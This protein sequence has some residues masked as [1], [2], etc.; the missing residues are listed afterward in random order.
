M[1][2][3]PNRCS[4]NAPCDL[5]APEDSNHMRYTTPGA[6]IPAPMDS[7]PTDWTKERLEECGGWWQQRLS[8]G[9]WKLRYELVPP[10]KLDEHAKASVDWSADLAYGVVKVLDPAK[11]E[12]EPF[13]PTDTE[14]NVVHELLHLHTIG[15]Q[16]PFERAEDYI[17]KPLYAELK[18]QSDEAEEQL[19]NHIARALVALK[20]E[21]KGESDR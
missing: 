15:L 14:V 2:P 8:L 4:P 12:K 3:C 1:P 7:P 13:M 10:D 5:C 19:I 11:E 6:I 17:P 9:N 16:R 21:S 20:R 18:G